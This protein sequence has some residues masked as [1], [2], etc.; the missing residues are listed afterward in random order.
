MSNLPK[1]T[2]TLLKVDPKTGS[3][4]N[5]PRYVDPNS[6]VYWTY[7]NESESDNKGNNES[8]KDCET[9]WEEE[10]RKFCTTC[11]VSKQSFPFE[12]KHLLNFHFHDSRPPILSSDL[13]NVDADILQEMLKEGHFVHSVSVPNKQVMY[14]FFVTRYKW[15]S[16]SSTS[17]FFFH[18]MFVRKSSTCNTKKNERSRSLT[19]CKVDAPI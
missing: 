2:R 14:N 13:Q 10:C 17:G 5:M 8:E 3:I 16:R 11:H 1:A 9:F 6:M 7:Y 19:I 4:L 12:H 18:T 15:T